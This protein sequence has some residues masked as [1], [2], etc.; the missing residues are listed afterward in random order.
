MIT[1]DQ[2]KDVLDRADKLY[3]YL[4]IDQKQIEWEEEDLRTQAP[5]FWEDPKRAEEQMKKV[6]A[7]KKWIDGYKDVRS[8]ADEL[9]LAFDF[10]KD[11][12]VTEEEVD[13]DYRK[14]IE[15]IEALEL[16]NML[17]QKEDPMDC[18]LKINSGA[19]GTEAQ[20]WAQMLMRMY[21]RWAEAHGYKVT[22]SSLLDGED[23]G[24]KSVT[25]QI[26]RQR[27]GE[28]SS[29]MGGEYAYGFLKSEN[30]VHRLVRVSPYN[31]QGKRM[32]SF[33]SVFVSPLVDDTIEVYV[34][35]A[36]L[37][38]DTFRSSGA[39]GQNVNKVESGVRLRYWYTDPDTGEEEEILIENTETRDQPKNKERAMALLRSQLY[40]RAMKKRL[41]AQ[42]KI[43][44]GKKKIEWGS[45][46]RSYVFD[47]KRV[48]DHR[49][50]YETR[51]VESVMN[52]KLDG[53]IKAYLMEFPVADEI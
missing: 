15:A 19:G 33:A 13:D 50:N 27:V 24:I 31:A 38:W 37:S 25:M 9:Q 16:M 35:P 29:G 48:K 36:K 23:A 47:D 10:Y 41:E 5:D 20:D 40:D 12:M 30:G 1:A 3:H 11:D 44:A 4:R 17:R 49:T 8:K 7:I 14:A 2:L 6:K 46:I 39:G 43:E 45:Q 42:A 32:T 22:I 21:M 34:D 18:V 53:F 28:Q 52:G 26:E 51:D